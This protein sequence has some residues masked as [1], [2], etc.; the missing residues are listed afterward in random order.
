MV[1][2]RSKYSTAKPLSRSVESSMN[3]SGNRKRITV[4]G[5]CTRAAAACRFARTGS[6]RSVI[7]S[8]PWLSVRALMVKRKRRE[9]GSRST[10]PCASSV[11]RQ[12]LTVVRAKRNF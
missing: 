9:S 2:P 5:H 1:I 11:A 10:K 4:I 3:M 6:S 7:G 8:K 12:R